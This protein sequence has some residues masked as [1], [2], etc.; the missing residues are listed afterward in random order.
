[1]PRARNIE[2]ELITS[3]TNIYVAEKM[4]VCSSAATVLPT[5]T[6]LGNTYLKLQLK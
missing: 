2:E 6:S 1:M 4:C 3:K 5:A